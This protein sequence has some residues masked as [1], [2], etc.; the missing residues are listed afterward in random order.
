M[1]VGGVVVFTYKDPGIRNHKSS[2]GS[3]KSMVLE[4]N[5]SSW[6]ATI[7]VVDDSLEVVVGG[8]A[9]EGVEEVIP[10]VV[11]IV[12]VVIVVVIMGMVCHFG[13]RA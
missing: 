1:V 2:K 12:V 8:F 7:E 6:V 3:T 9:D 4:V 11:V 10:G 5:K 13:G